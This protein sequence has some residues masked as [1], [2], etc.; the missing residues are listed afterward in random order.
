MT[1]G[2]E[3]LMNL[4]NGSDYNNNVPYNTL[5]NSSLFPKALLQTNL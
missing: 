1:E 4:G 5:A 3:K 2:E